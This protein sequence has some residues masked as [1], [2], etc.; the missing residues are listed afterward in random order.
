MPR[1]RAFNTSRKKMY[2]VS[3]LC[4]PMNGKGYTVFNDT[5]VDV[6]PAIVMQYTGVDD[7]R[8]REL[9]EHDV[10][11]AVMDH[12]GSG[13]F[14]IR[15]YPGKYVLEQDNIK[16]DLHAAMMAQEKNLGHMLKVGNAHEGKEG[17]KV[18][19]GNW[20]GVIRE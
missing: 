14:C 3:Y 12:A 1:F 10:V 4:Y 6:S 18:L 7:I 9:Y 13:L 15:W 17:Q 5:G 11:E 8:G 19:P 20:P 16:I 2:Q